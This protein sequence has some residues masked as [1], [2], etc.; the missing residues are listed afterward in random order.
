VAGF[1]DFCG[2]APAGQT[3]LLGW[4][5][6]TG[7]EVSDCAADLN[8]FTRLDSLQGLDAGRKVWAEV[9]KTIGRRLQYHNS[10]PAPL[11]ILLIAEIRVYRYQ[12]IKII[13]RQ[14]Q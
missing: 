8:N 5:W 10:D 2:P 4:M 13:F 14:F 3:A 1:L 9:L 11:Q 6:K 12:R 7:C